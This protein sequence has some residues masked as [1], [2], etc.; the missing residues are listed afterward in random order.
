MR[1][2]N[3]RRFLD[4]LKREGELRVIEEAVDPYLELAEIHRR[5]VARQGPA[6]LFTRVSRTQF[7]VVTNLFG[8]RRRI[9]LA[10][11]EEPLRFFK[12]LAE[13][14]E[15]LMPPSLPKL[16][17]F[18]DLAK[19]GLRI[20]MK[21]CRNGPVLERVMNPARLTALP[22]IQTWPKDGGSFLT[23]PLVYT[24]NPLTHK[25]NL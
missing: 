21:N 7:P 24:E 18:R 4:T 8:T 1:H 25:S 19:T 6:L 22:Q 2:P 14:A 16:W 12:R 5:T 3:L 9:D 13:A 23:L 15:V 10:F 17:S 20:G 11:G